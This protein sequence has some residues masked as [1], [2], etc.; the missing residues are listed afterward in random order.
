MEV[1]RR[2]KNMYSSST[3]IVMVNNIPGKAVDNIRQSLRQGDLPSMHFFSF[4]IDPLLVFLEKRLKGIL[5]TALPVLGP[6]Q[7]GHQQLL[8]PEER[9]K[10]IGYA[11]DVNLL[12]FENNFLFTLDYVVCLKLILIF[13]GSCYNQ[14]YQPLFKKR[15]ILK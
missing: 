5:V 9:Y 10:L 14:E 12:K 6:V 4:G 2:P 7:E 3:T 8:P 11:D 13:I 1:I 15:N